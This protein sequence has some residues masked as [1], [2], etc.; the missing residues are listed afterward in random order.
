MHFKDY[1]RPSNL[2]YITTSCVKSNLSKICVRSGYHQRYLPSIPSYNYNPG[3]FPKNDKQDYWRHWS[4]FS[5][6]K[7]FIESKKINGLNSSPI[8]KLSD[9]WDKFID[10]LNKIPTNLY[11]AQGAQFGVCRE[12]IHLHSKD[13]YQNLLEQLSYAKDP[14]QGYYMEWLWMYI[15][16]PEWKNLNI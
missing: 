4:D 12:R 2:C 16:L 7:K 14:Y 9:Y 11:Y 1:L 8:L 15:L 13:F 10:P 3:I 6:F 5:K